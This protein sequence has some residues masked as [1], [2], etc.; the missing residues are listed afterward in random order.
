MGEVGRNHRIVATA[1]P[2]RLSFVGGGTDIPDFYLEHGGAVVSTTLDKY[3]YVT[4]KHHG[5]PFAERFRINYSK[6]ENVD[7]IDDIENGIVRECLRLLDMDMPLFISTIADLPGSSGLGSSS[8]FAV[9][10]L[11]ALHLLRGE[12]VSAGQLAEEASHVELCMLKGPIGKQDQYAAAFGGLN[13]IAF[14]QSGRVHIDPVWLSGDDRRA[15]F[16]HSLLFW[17]GIQRD[18]N[19]ILAD[20]QRGISSR[21]AE[22]HAM[23]DMAN[24]CRDML[25]RTF[26]PLRFG[27]LLHQGWETKQR[28]STL[29]S[30][31]RIDH[32][33]R[34]ALAAG[35][36]GGKMAGAGG[37]GFLYLVV[38]PGRQAEVRHTLRE[39][40]EVPVAYEPRGA[41][42]LFTSIAY[43]TLDFAQT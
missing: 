10:L 24:A 17:T 43:R 26:D 9:G 1:T 25:L 19:Q 12:D 20:Q 7:R 4:V 41:R 14:D 6:A 21:L 22:L 29:I 23:R 34:A 36:L 28:L 42:K 13:H 18:A 3:I 5:P 8:S 40:H 31:E 15:L 30:N 32:W 35:A 2:L 33:Y 27:A 37:G 16:G 38:P 11:Y 39:M